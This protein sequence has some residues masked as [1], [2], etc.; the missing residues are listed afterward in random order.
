[1]ILNIAHHSQ[2]RWVLTWNAH[3]LG[4]LQNRVNLIELLDSI[5]VEGVFQRESGLKT[6]RLHYQGRFVLKGSRLGKKRLL[7]IFSQ[8][9]ETTEFI[10]EPE[11]LY[12]STKYCRKS[13]T[14]DQGP[15]Y[16]GTES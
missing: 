11:V 10:L 1:M 4:G 2:K 9:C 6:G 5:A 14:R 12:D 15:L 13:E 3:N 16:V 7:E 8:I